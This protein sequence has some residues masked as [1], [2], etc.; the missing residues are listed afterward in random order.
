VQPGQPTGVGGERVDRRVVVG[1]EELV[2]QAR[3]LAEVQHDEQV[4]RGVVAVE[5]RRDAGRVEGGQES[6]RR[7]LGDEQLQRIVATGIVRGPRLQPFG[8]RCPRR[9]RAAQVQPVDGAAPAVAASTR[10]RGSPV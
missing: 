1:G 5:P 8:D 3:A 4:G 2:G 7:Q 10:P 9:V 6:Q